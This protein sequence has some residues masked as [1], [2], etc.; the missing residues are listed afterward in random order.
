MRRILPVVELAAALC[1]AAPAWAG[2][3]WRPSTSPCYWCVRDAIYERTRLISHLEASPDVD[4]AVKG[5]PIH[6][7]RADIHR[8]R[9]WLGPVWEVRAEPCCYW[10]KHLYIH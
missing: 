7:A 3:F 6:A 4:D 8:L 10:R 9:S 5:P 1:I 2:D